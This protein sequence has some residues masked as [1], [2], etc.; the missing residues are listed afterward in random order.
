MKHLMGV[1]PAFLVI[2]AAPVNAQRSD[3][4]VR[5]L[6]APLH[7]G[8]ASL[9]PELSIGVV[10]GAPEYMFTSISEIAVGRDGTMYVLE[11]TTGKG[12]LRMYDSAGKYIRTVGGTGDG[13]GEFRNPGG[14]A[15]LND[16]K[17][18]LYD[19]NNSRINVYSGAGDY[20]SSWRVPGYNVTFNA[21]QTLTLA[22]SG[23]LSIKFNIGTT[24]EDRRR[25]VARL[26]PD[27][28]VLDTI[29]DPV[30]PDISLPPV[31]KR[32]ER[33]GITLGIPYSRRSTWTWSP[34]GYFVTGRTDVYALDLRIPR[35]S[36]VNAKWRD[37][38]PI[39]SLR[40]T[41]ASVPV[42]RAERND[43]EEF[44][45][46]QLRRREGT[47][48]GS[49]SSIPAVKPIFTSVLFGTD[50]RIWLLM[51]APSVKF[52][53][54]ARR[55]SDG[56]VIPQLGWRQPVVFD[57]IDPAGRYIGRIAVP[58]G[59]YIETMRGDYAWGFTRTE[60]DVPIVKRFRIAWR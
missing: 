30:L 11:S 3:T 14:M 41:V 16:G 52:T 2:V 7:A 36:D 47:Q 22:P 56:T 27:G 45:E 57:I 26:R 9:V 5:A 38:D 58:E 28:T 46:A 51:S 44:L 13:P 15:L 12:Q 49:V 48:V 19:P 6:G 1:I 21:Y 17:L 43:Q 42:S 33:S 37:G 8:V 59:T 18:V 35:S 60:D 34:L 24:R 39:T 10:D 32:T 31:T 53:P 55:A 4:I 23:I 29:A 40:R 50:G 54:E 25:G 20:V